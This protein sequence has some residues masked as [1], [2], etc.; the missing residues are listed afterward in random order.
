MS[1]F[2]D[3]LN[4]VS[5]IT[6]QPMGFRAGQPASEK[7]RI[8]LIASLTQAN[9]EGLAERVIG[10]DAGLLRIPELSSGARAFKAVSQAVSDIPWGGWL[11]GIAGGEVEPVT[12]VGFDFV[13]F[14]PT[15]TPLAIKDDKV[16]KILEVEAS[17]SEGLLRVIGELPVDAVLVASEQ[18]EHFLTWHHLMLFQ[19]CA[20]LLTKP[21][22]V[23]TPSNVSAS[24]LQA[25]W[26]AG[27]NGVVV[28]IGTGQ[29]IGRLK[30]LRQ[31][32]NKLAFPLPRKRKKAEA[33]LPH[34]HISEEAEIATE[35]E[36]E[37]SDCSGLC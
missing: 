10:A 25:L 30:E 17:L 12:K 5:Q 1:Q 22:L 33:L 18:E 16:G 4:R 11:R 15:N 36:E 34:T 2:I 19:H 14:K 31:A 32:I 20:D 35:E 37:L 21:L 9:I 23:S 27:V 3:K 8:L 13:V 24:E 7:P 26:E 6:P 29:P 28:E